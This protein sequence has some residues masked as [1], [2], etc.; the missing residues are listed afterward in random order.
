MQQNLPKNEQATKGSILDRVME[1][2]NE[3]RLQEADPAFVLQDLFSHLEKREAEILRRRHGLAGGEGETL[4]EVGKRYGITRERVRQ[5]EQSA[6]QKVKK[7]IQNSASVG[8]IR[9]VVKNLFARH[10][11]ILAYE[12]F[13]DRLQEGG[14]ALAE[15]TKAAW[16]FFLNHLLKGEVASLEERADWRGGWYVPE[17]CWDAVE[18]VMKEVKAVFEE[19]KQPLVWEEFHELFKARQVAEKHGQV[20]ARHPYSLNEEALKSYVR[21]SDQIG[22]NA[23]GRFGLREW[24][25]VTP[26]RV[27]DKI[28]VIL[29]HYNK[30]IHYREIAR[31]IQEHK[32]DH[33]KASPETVHNEL[34]LDQRFVLVGRGVYALREWGYE[35]GVV[36]EVVARVLREQGPLPKEKVVEEVLKQRLVKPETVALTLSNRKRF[37]RL[38]DG[39]YAVV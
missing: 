16:H 19:A 28:Y 26:K 29:R 8:A 24:P 35:P 33:K 4:E 2:H 39:T 1:S 37:N 21:A 15:S 17:V 10:G 11:G 34:I 7:Q 18:S 3:E 23:V 32:F 25:E 22:Q 38:P 12:H 6:L 14:S 27:G 30:P 13:F 20:L 9:Q 31:L 36:A 5:I